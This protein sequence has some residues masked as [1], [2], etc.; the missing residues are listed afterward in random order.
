MCYILAFS[1]VLT[2]LLRSRYQQESSSGHLLAPVNVLF[3]QIWTDL[4]SSYCTIT[5]ASIRKD[6]GAFQALLSSYNCAVCHYFLL[7]NA[8]RLQFGKIL[9]FIQ[10]L[11]FLKC[12]GF[13][14]S[15]PKKLCRKCVS[16]VLHP[17]SVYW[18]GRFAQLLQTAPC[19]IGV[20]T[21]RG[22]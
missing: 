12:E 16:A 20:V 1:N 18:R 21:A 14:V 3:G 5:S 9:L 17:K 10:L 4:L 22:L 6:P 8:V 2:K 7:S 15:L 19:L 13:I 11:F